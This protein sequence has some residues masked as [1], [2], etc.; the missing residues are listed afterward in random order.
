MVYFFGWEEATLLKEKRSQVRRT[1]SF[2][3]LPMI[4]VIDLLRLLQVNLISNK[5]RTSLY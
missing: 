4:Q 3:F 1:K 5:T 2:M